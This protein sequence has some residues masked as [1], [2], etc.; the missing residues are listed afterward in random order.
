MTICTR[1]SKNACGNCVL[2]QKTPFQ[3]PF[4]LNNVF[5]IAPHNYLFVNLVIFLLPVVSVG[6]ITVCPTGSLLFAFL[7]LFLFHVLVSLKF[8]RGP[9]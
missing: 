8:H 7:E 6:S 9:L 3:F 1:G 2:I 5:N 4:Y